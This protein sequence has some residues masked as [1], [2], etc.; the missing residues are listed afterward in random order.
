MLFDFLGSST[1]T[2]WT[3]IVGDAF[4]VGG[5]VFSVISTLHFCST[6]LFNFSGTVS[7]TDVGNL[8]GSKRGCAGQSSTTHGYVTGG[9]L[10]S[11]S[12]TGINVQ[13]KYAFAS[14]G[15]ASDIGDLTSGSIY[16]AGTQ[17]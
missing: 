17:Y 12:G 6:V 11:A 14:D 16:C 4:G 15:D 7:V 9:G 10:S 5:S 2:C 8:S 3:G 13:D 1:G